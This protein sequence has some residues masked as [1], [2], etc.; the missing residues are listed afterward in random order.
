[1]KKLIIP[2]I[3]L[4]IL[5]LLC[6]CAKNEDNP[7]YPPA[8]SEDV[9]DI[10]DPEP[11]FTWQAQDLHTGFTS[12]TEVL[13]SIVIIK[14]TN[15][16]NEYSK[17]YATEL[18]PVPKLLSSPY[19]D[20]YT[21]DFFE[22]NYL[23]AVYG[24]APSGSIQRKMKDVTF[25]DG[26]INIIV[27]DFYPGM[28]TDDCSGW[29]HLITIPNHFEVSK[30]ENI[31]VEYYEIAPF[32][33]VDDIYFLPKDKTVI[34]EGFVN[35]EE[36]AVS[37]DIVAKELAKKEIEKMDFEYK[38]VQ[39]AYDLSKDWWRVTF[40]SVKNEKEYINVYIDSKGITQSIIK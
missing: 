12:A 30:T 7:K 5:I 21:D 19:T 34:E 9:T 40:Y 33:Y 16:L 18:H 1:M 24:F 14:S 32:G 4:L 10:N 36:I 35:T 23:I 11:E 28:G 37:D 17:S 15:D 27:F 3:F 6:S 38:N 25:K 20:E 39:V 8:P 26:K 22:E 2:I 31:N 13:P 29:T